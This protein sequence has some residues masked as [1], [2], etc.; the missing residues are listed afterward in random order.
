MLYTYIKNN[1]EIEYHRLNLWYFISFIFGISACFKITYLYESFSYTKSFLLLCF[2]IAIFIASIALYRFLVE[3]YS[4]LYVFIIY[5]FLAFILGIAV[6]KIRIS[7]ISTEP[8]QDVVTL[9][10]SGIVDFIKPENRNNLKIILTNITVH[11]V[12][13]SKQKNANLPNLK[14]IKIQIPNHYINKLCNNDMIRATVKLYPLQSAILPNSYDFGFYSYMS[15]I[16]ATGYAIN[17]LKILKKNKSNNN[18]LLNDINHYIN[19]I[20]IKIYTRLVSTMG[21]KYGNFAAAILIGETHAIESDIINIMRDSGI[22]HILSVSGLHLSLVA[23]IFFISARFIL[24]ISNFISYT[25]DV[26]KLAAIISVIG[27]FCYL[28]ISG[29]NIATIRAFIMTT[30]FL[31]SIILERRIYP[32]RSMMLAAVVI[33]II[34]PEYVFHPSFQL[35]FG[36]VLSLISGYEFYMKY[37]YFNT[38]LNLL[39]RIFGK[40]YKIFNTM[41]L[42][43]FTNIYSSILSSIIT[44]PLVIYHFY[45]FSV[46]ATITNLI[47][48]P[49]MSFAIMPVALLSIVLMPFGMDGFLLQVLSYLIDVMLQFA[50]Y[51]VSIPNSVYHIGSIS[52]W[53]IMLFIFGFLWICI[54]QE[55]WRFLGILLMLLSVYMIIYKE[56]PDLM[57]DN[58]IKVMAIK[59]S[60]NNL[61]I[62]AS[63]KISQFTANYWSS[64]YGGNYDYTN[65][66]QHSEIK[67]KIFTISNNTKV[68]FNYKKCNIADIQIIMSKYLRCNFNETYNHIIIDNSQ[69]TKFQMILI[70]CKNKECNVE[71]KE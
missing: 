8:I 44:A 52:I 69:L 39:Y 48:V 62:Y 45:K 34:Y 16:Q 51:I 23:I 54:W 65:V 22:A 56:R 10:I 25:L 59:N 21:N 43:V 49:L 12:K 31:L 6:C 47:A 71:Y 13:Y 29:S 40:Y 14:K 7:F 50:G 32:L 57:Y 38:N 66:I 33:L 1:L 20:R 58:R 28:L 64:W 53:S 27:S 36:A 46:Y 3:K 5:C 26:K 19:N 2:I 63:N 35:S 70:F 18:S 11:N 9:D 17:T 68:A 4:I 55:V 15:S 41:F 30:V 67:D 24:N 60:Y 37:L 61:D 42:Y